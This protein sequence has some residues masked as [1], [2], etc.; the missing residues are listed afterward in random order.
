MYPSISPVPRIAAHSTKANMDDRVHRH[1]RRSHQTAVCVVADRR[2]GAQLQ[3]HRL[4]AAQGS[5]PALGPGD[6]RQAAQCRLRA[7][8]LGRPAFRV[9]SR[10]PHPGPRPGAA[11]LR[12]R[13]GDRPG[14][15]DRPVLRGTGMADERPGRAGVV[16]VGQR[17]PAPADAR[18]PGCRPADPGPSSRHLLAARPRA[19]LGAAAHPAAAGRTVPDAG[20]GERRG[21]RCLL[22]AE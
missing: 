7:A 13:A 1:G 19:V 3:D 18:R 10:F 14:D 21:G 16:A 22:V 17:G 15:P 20:D 4:A 9:R 12:H 11:H 2:S 5:T 6:D 8:Q